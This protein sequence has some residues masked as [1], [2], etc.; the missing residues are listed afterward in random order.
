M[1][2]PHQVSHWTNSKTE[3]RVVVVV[4]MLSGAHKWSCKLLPNPQTL[5]L[6]VW[7]PCMR[8]AKNICNCLHCGAHKRDFSASLAN[9]KE[10]KKEHVH[11]SLDRQV[12]NEEPS[13][14]PQEFNGTIRDL[15]P[16][17]NQWEYCSFDRFL[18][19]DMKIPSANVEDASGG[20]HELAV[21]MG[22]EEDESS[23]S[24]P[25]FGP[26]ASRKSN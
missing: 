10:R 23:G 12:V 2:L 17:H 22:L 13:C 5:D 26:R 1:K 6:M 20:G 4:W 24:V 3:D 15:G 11:I 7:W 14:E 8:T 25:L 18:V 16:R 9:P 19:I 21:P